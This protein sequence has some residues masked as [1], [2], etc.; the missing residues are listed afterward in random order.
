M[1]DHSRELAVEAISVVVRLVEA[2]GSPVDEVPGEG[3]QASR[4]SAPD[5]GDPP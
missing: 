4:F 1:P 3:W 5:C 2:T